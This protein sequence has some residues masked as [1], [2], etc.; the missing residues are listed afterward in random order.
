[1]ITLMMFFI[2]IGVLFFVVGSPFIARKLVKNVELR[3]KLYLDKV[4]EVVGIVGILT[5]FFMGC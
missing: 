3:K 1:M 2:L 4:I 5:L